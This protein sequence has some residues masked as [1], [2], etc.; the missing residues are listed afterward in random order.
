M[1][2]EMSTLK[3]RLTNAEY[4]QYRARL[5]RLKKIGI[6]IGCADPPR[7]PDRFSVEQ[8]DRELARLYELP[9]D[10]VAFVGHA[11]LLV[12]RSGVLIVDFDMSIQWGYVLDLEDLNES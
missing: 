5:L 1:G 4:L 3:R 9:L 11:E 7:V 6:A 10:Q 12:P 2:G 8:V